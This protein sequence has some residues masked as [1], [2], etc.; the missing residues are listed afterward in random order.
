MVMAHRNGARVRDVVVARNISHTKEIGDHARNL[1]LARR[2]VS[3]HRFLHLCRCVLGDGDAFASKRAEH[4]SA[5][6]ADSH[7]RAA[8]R[9]EEELLNRGNLG[10]QRRARIHDEVEEERKPPASSVCGTVSM[11]AACSSTRCP[12]VPSTMATPVRASPGSTPRLS[13]RDER[14]AVS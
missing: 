7:R 14:R 13:S 2:A 5:C 1:R 8:V 9:R 11:Q 6:F 3:A 12:G 4:Y 10:S